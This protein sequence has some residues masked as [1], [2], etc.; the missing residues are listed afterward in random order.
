MGVLEL[1]NLGGDGVRVIIIMLLFDRIW[2][3]LMENEE[4]S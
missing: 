2:R 3:G 1:M 4:G